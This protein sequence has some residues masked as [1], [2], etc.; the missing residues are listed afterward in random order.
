LLIPEPRAATIRAG[1]QGAMF[2]TLDRSSYL[3]TLK[4][5]QDKLH[6]VKSEFLIKCPIL[7][8]TPLKIVH[9]IALFGHLKYLIDEILICCLH[10]II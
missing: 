10:N 1:G 5:F 6:L 4:V 2:A 7:L 3:Q 8:N 9:E